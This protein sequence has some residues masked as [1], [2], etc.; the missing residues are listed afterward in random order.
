MQ[1]LNDI[2]KE[3]A[4]T[5]YALLADMPRLTNRDIMSITGKK[6]NL[7]VGALQF[8]PRFTQTRDNSNFIVW[9]RA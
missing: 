4:D 1:N 3:L 5:V 2:K 7:I 6:Q 8:D 9:M